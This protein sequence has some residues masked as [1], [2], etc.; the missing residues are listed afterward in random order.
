[1]TVPLTGMLPEPHHNMPIP[2]AVTVIVVKPAASALVKRIAHASILIRLQASIAGVTAALP[3]LA[4]SR[5][6]IAASATEAHIWLCS[7]LDCDHGAVYFAVPLTVFV[8]VRTA[9]ARPTAEIM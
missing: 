6:A 7:H 4:G 9:F 8:L 1:M 2:A 5:A 3:I